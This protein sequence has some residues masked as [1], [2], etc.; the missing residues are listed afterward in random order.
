METPKTNT[1]VEE[2]LKCQDPVDPLN[3]EYCPDGASWKLAQ[4]YERLKRPSK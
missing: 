3:P 4:F 2:E 1:K